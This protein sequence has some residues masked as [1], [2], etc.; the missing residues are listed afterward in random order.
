MLGAVIFYNALLGGFLFLGTFLG[1]EAFHIFFYGH[2][3]LT[4]KLSLG[5]FKISGGAIMFFLAQYLLRYGIGMA[6]NS[7]A[8]SFVGFLFCN[9]VSNFRDILP[10]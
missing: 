6:F 4:T 1:A 5:I 3:T 2:L 7:I 10:R 8:A 9:S